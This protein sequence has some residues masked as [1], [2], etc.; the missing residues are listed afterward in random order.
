M[1]DPAFR[2]MLL[3]A[4]CWTGST[5]KKAADLCHSITNAS[6]CMEKVIDESKPLLAT[7]SRLRVSVDTVK[8]IRKAAVTE[9]SVVYY[10]FIAN[11]SKANIFTFGV[12]RKEKTDSKSFGLDIFCR[13][14][15]KSPAMK[16]K[17]FGRITLCKSR[18]VCDEF[19][20]D[21]SA[22][23]SGDI[24]KV[25]EWDV[26][27]LR[28][29]KYL[30]LPEFGS[31]TLCKSGQ[32]CSEFP[33]DVSL[34]EWDVTTKHPL[35]LRSSKAATTAMGFTKSIDHRRQQEYYQG[36]WA[37]L[38]EEKLDNVV[39]GAVK[40]VIEEVRNRYDD[41]FDKNVFAAF[42]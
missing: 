20:V 22:S 39:D 35:Q 24:R 9:P 1:A 17:M 21:V 15:W 2:V 11:V 6:E 3:A 5:T 34:S 14:G 8:G 23:V 40:A 4:L 25:S 28:S 16:I 26:L 27:Q 36:L 37:F 10:S 13:W 19:P 33:V 7:L 42:A 32:V 12:E 18:Q 31:I 30:Y 29:G 38:F 41:W